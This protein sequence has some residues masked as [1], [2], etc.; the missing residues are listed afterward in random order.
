MDITTAS[1]RRRVLPAELAFSRVVLFAA[2][3][4]IV[5]IWFGTLGVRHL[6]PPDEGRYAE[7]AREM[8]RSGDWVTIRYNG[9]KY[10]EKPPFHMWVTAVSYA[11]FGVGEWQSRLCVALAGCIGAVASMGAAARWWG[12]RV[13]ALTGLVLTAA[14]LWNLAAHFNSLDMT[15]SGA[16]ACALA[17]LLCAQHPAATPGARRGWM[18]ACWLATGVA[19]LTKGLVGLLLPGLVLVIYSVVAG[20]LRV[21]RRLHMPAGIA[22]MLL[23][24]MPWF[25]LVARRNP[26]FMRFFFIHEHWERY[27][28][29]VHHRA[30]AIWYFVPLVIGGF[31]PWLGLSAQ[32]AR[33]TA[34]EWRAA[35]AARR[36]QPMVLLAVWAVTIFVFFS[37]SQSKLPG[38]IVP[39][40][41]ALAMLA[42]VALNRAGEPLW[43]RQTT[44]MLGIGALGL[45]VGAPVVAHLHADNVPNALYR[46]FSWWV[47]AAFA[48]ILAGVLASRRLAR[49]GAGCDSVV[50]YAL[51][52]F[53][54]F[55]LA[56]LGYECVG[57]VS[58]GETLLPRIEGVLDAHMPL[59]GVLMLDHTL[60]FYL[61]HQLTM[62]GAVDELTFGATQEPGKTVSSIAGFLPVWRDG[63]RAVALMSPQT[64]EAL[65]AQGW[66]MYPVARDN[67][68]VVVAN[69]PSVPGR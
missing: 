13:G 21:W 6:L 7:I 14:P 28:S 24:T 10:F 50:A 58:S 51:A 22:L 40:F 52:M 62:V 18:L 61:Q 34:A 41:P 66:R 59:Y 57:R 48:V 17:F 5:L 35:R 32:M 49:N 23:V 39:V 60:P 45:C 1:P 44:L 27:T 65:R 15:L 56:L 20:D 16:M 3:A 47:A 54:G 69:F 42:A 8:L 2:M 26:E 9:L 12:P 36:F 63:P 37:L 46:Q 11:L 29:T 4:A 33:E 55:T 67:R 30:G 64:F 53:V 43:R 25:W 38:Y 31:L 19:V 68:R